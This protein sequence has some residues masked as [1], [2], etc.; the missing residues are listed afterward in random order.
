[1]A[2]TYKQVTNLLASIVSAVPDQLNC[3]GCYELIAELADAESRGDELS[4]ALEAVRIHLTQCPCC[5]Y[6]YETM[7]EAIA[8]ADA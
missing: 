7:L 8:A 2:I 3:D 1:M 4:T 5:A 6:E